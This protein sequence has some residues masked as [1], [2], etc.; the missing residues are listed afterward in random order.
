MS[1]EAYRCEL[2]SSIR[3][4]FKNTLLYMNGRLSKICLVNTYG[5]RKIPFF[6]T[7]CMLQYFED[8]CQYFIDKGTFWEFYDEVKGVIK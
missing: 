7:F 5:A 8:F 6:A 4:F 2:P 3:V 1:K